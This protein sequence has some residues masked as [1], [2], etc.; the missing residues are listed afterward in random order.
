[1]QIQY[2]RNESVGDMEE[3]LNRRLL[4]NHKEVNKVCCRKN[5]SSIWKFSLP[6]L[7]VDFRDRATWYY[8][9]LCH[10]VEPG[11]QRETMKE[12]VKYTKKRHPYYGTMSSPGMP[13]S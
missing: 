8:F 12:V 6:F 3:N 4:G 13:S 2:L 9:T 7:N 11:S 5:K 10:S 1:M